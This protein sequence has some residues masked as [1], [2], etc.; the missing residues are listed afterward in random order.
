VLSLAPILL[1]VRLVL[2]R[3]A[4]DRGSD[5]RNRQAP[6]PPAAFL[7]TKGMEITWQAVSPVQYA[8]VGTDHSGRHPAVVGPLPD[9]WARFHVGADNGAAVLYLQSDQLPNLVSLFRY[10]SLQP[11]GLPAGDASPVPCSSE[12]GCNV[13]RCQRQKNVGVCVVIANSGL[14]VHPVTV[15]FAQWLVPGVPFAAIEK[16]GP[17]TNSASWGLVGQPQ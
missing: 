6:S 8:W 2:V 13:Q 1:L 10:S 4:D 12:V 15:V 9:K 7:A 3:I 16:G 11:S 14:I 17:V 5:T